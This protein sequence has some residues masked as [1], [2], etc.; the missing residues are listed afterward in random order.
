MSDA[1][2][3]L[4]RETRTSFHFSIMEDRHRA[5]GTWT[6]EVPSHCSWRWVGKNVRRDDVTGLIPYRR[7]REPIS[8]PSNRLTETT[9]PGFQREPPAH[10]H[11]SVA[12]FYLFPWQQTEAAAGNT[13]SACC[14]FVCLFVCLFDWFLHLQLS[15]WTECVAFVLFLSMFV[16]CE[17]LDR[18]AKN[19]Q[20]NKQTNK[21]KSKNSYLRSWNFIFYFLGEKMKTEHADDSVSVNDVLLS[22]RR[23][24]VSAVQESN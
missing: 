14:L 15:C 8:A 1:A 4:M 20:T 18:K 11:V 17:Y 3:R 9:G 22:D 5:S 2:T 23:Y 24:W 10:K 19:K 6:T 13:S 16:S 7:M 12:E 21:Q